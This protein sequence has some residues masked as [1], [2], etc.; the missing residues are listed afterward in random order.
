LLFVSDKVLGTGI[1]DLGIRISGLSGLG[2]SHGR[3]KTAA[4]ITL[5][6][7]V[8]KQLELARLPGFV[9]PSKTACVTAWSPFLA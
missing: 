6:E 9:I 8:I 2:F 1:S 4:V 7:A 5:I 3:E